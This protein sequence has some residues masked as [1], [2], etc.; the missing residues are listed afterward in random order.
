VIGAVVIT[1]LLATDAGPRSGLQVGAA[2]PSFEPVHVAGPDRGTQACPIC[3]YG[4][5]P[6]ILVVT[7]GAAKAAPLATRVEQL[8][9]RGKELKGFVVV[10]GVAPAT[11]RRLARE[12]GIVRSALCYPQ[13]GQEVKDLHRKLQINPQAESTIIVFRNFRVTANFVNVD[14]ARFD[15]VSAAVANM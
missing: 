7:R 11:L 2:V 1:L 3:T 6:M 12:Q 9:S 4:A 15:A 13:P 5:R 10:T 14:P 8:V